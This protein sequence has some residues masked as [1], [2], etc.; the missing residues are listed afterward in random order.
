MIKSFSTQ[1]GISFYNQ[2]SRIFLYFKY[3]KKLIPFILKQNL[4]ILIKKKKK[5]IAK[6]NVFF[7]EINKVKNIKLTIFCDF[8]K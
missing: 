2:I 8:K 1:K 7:L 5:E 3:I 4:K 6:K